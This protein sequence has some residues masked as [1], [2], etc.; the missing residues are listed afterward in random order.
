LLTACRLLPIAD[1]LV[2]NTRP[3]ALDTDH[4]LRASTLANVFFFHARDPLGIAPPGQQYGYDEYVIYFGLYGVLLAGIG[5]PFAWRRH[6]WL[7]AVA[8]ASVVLALGHFVPWSPWTLLQR[9]VFPFTSMRVSSRFLLMLALVL[10]LSMGIAVDELHAWVERRFDWKAGRAWVRYA[11]VALGLLAIGDTLAVGRAIVRDRFREEPPRTVTASPRFYYGRPDTPA[12]D[13]DP[14]IINQ[15]RQNHAWPEC[16]AVGYAFHYHAPI[17][18]G[19]LPQARS[20]DES[21]VVRDVTR[22]NHT[23]RFHVDARAP[24]QVQ[25]N[26]AYDEGW[27]ANVGTLANDRHLLTLSI[28]PG[29]HD[30]RLWYW[31]R[32]LTLGLSLSLLGVLATL[33]VALFGQRSQKR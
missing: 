10:C 15:P 13:L 19:D 20:V 30:V 21:T 4:M 2:H 27:R 26:S 17:W 6:R 18:T 1:K 33:G 5:L 3:V 32:T 9:H 25:V 28:P 14:D 22:T 8:L 23:F 24:A 16:R 29:S 12:D 11:S 7:F 31:P